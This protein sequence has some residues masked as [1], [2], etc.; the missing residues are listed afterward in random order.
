MERFLLKRRDVVAHLFHRPKLAVKSKKASSIRFR[1]R[2]GE[3]IYLFL[4]DR[5]ELHR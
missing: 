4:T 1:Q 3:K 2:M 5:G